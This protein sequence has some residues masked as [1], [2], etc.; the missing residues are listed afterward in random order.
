MT[1]KNKIENSIVVQLSKDDEYQ[2]EIYVYDNRVAIF[3]LEEKFGV[4]IG[5]CRYRRC[6]EKL[7]DLAWEKR[8]N[9]MVR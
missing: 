7:Y 9:M 2:A 5:V 3:S 8:K 6:L 1:T 4:M